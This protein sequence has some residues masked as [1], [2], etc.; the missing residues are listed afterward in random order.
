M[1]HTCNMHTAYMQHAYHKCIA[2]A[3]HTQMQHASSIPFSPWYMCYRQGGGAEGRRG[4]RARARACVG[5]SGWAHK[6]T[7]LRRLGD[8]VCAEL[9]QVGIVPAVVRAS[10][11]MQ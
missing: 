5:A 2:H 10:A 8:E 6:H 9:V 4:A 7:H 3:A 1:Q 11:R